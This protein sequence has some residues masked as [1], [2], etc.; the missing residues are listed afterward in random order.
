MDPLKISNKATDMGCKGCASYGGGFGE[1]G[2]GGPVTMTQQ[3]VLDPSAPD[4]AYL[5][6]AP[7]LQDW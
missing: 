6:Y 7:A 1:E 3:N 5:H 2:L 4:L